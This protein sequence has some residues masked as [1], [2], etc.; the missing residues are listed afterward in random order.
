MKEFYWEGILDP[1]HT[2]EE[3]MR[4]IQYKPIVRCKRKTER[5]LGIITSSEPLTENKL[6]G[7]MMILNKEAIVEY[8]KMPQPL[9]LVGCDTGVLK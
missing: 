1:N 9:N 4:H 8:D 7:T 3:T 2:M 6:C 5:P